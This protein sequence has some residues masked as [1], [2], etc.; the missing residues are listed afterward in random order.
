[1]S[2]CPCE[3]LIDGKPNVPEEDPVRTVVVQYETKPDRADE[4]QALIERVFAELDE[5]AP[6]G[7]SYVSL[8]LADG[9]SFIHIVVETAEGAIPLTDIAAFREFTK[10][11]DD[12]CV[13]GPT[14]SG[15]QV[16]GE[17]RFVER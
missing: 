14:P 2:S 9:V 10:D 7:F 11:I 12:R 5:R 15:A 3:S 17:Y 6:D 16:V 4:N 1:M 8:R 13:K